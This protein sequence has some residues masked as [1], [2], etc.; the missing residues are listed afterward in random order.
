MSV[1]D[2]VVALALKRLNVGQ[3]NL[4]SE[5]LNALNA[6]ARRKIKCFDIPFSFGRV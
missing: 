4:V 5:V 6:I 3:A 1:F 2:H